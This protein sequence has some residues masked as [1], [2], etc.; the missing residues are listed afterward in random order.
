M[1]EDM[2]ADLADAAWP[3]AAL[4]AGIKSNSPENK[5]DFRRGMIDGYFN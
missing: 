5:A 1:T 2:I 4:E 3:R